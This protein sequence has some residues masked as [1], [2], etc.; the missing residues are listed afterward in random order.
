M[1]SKD[2]IVL[3]VVVRIVGGPTFLRRCLDCLVTQTENRPIEIIV[4]YDST[5]TNI[6]LLIKDFSQVIFVNMGLVKTDAPFDSQAVLHELYDRR[7]ATGLK[8]AQGRILALIEDYGAPA[9]DW[10]EQVL[11]AHRLPHGVIGGA[12]EQENPRP[13]NWA[14]Y[15]LDFGRYQLPLCEGPTDHLTDVNVS[16][17]REAVE[18]VREL[19]EER[20]NEAIVHWALAS[21]GVV[22]WLRPD[23][24][25]HENRRELSFSDA[26]VERYW[27]GR[28]FG[29]VRR[30]EGK[31]VSPFLYI[32][33][34]PAIPFVL[35]GRIMRKVLCGR[36][37]RA[38]FLF[39][40]PLVVILSLSWCLGEFVGYVT[41]REF[42]G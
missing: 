25:V 34:C 36:R 2:K 19:W 23:I 22:F 12:V 42:L 3:S 1:V 28:L 4:P 41:G 15:F 16:Y 10:C 11:K 27:W 32:V 8:V 18:S 39:S 21:R 20:Y 33:F 7:T 17:K 9:S 13:L 6:E 31:S 5:I 29:C 38:K 26:I 24:V 35:L 14:L 37:N 40:F 30:R